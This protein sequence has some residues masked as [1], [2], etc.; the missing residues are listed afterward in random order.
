M[1]TELLEAKQ[2]HSHLGPYLVIGMKMGNF[3]RTTLGN[4]PFSYRI[5]TSVGLTPPTSCVIDGLQIT[6]PCTVGNSMIRVEELGDIA[7][8]A[9]QDD[10]RIELQLKSA[11]RKRIDNDTTRENEENIAQDLW[12]TEIEELFEIDISQP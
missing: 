4:K 9:Q 10:R 5:H 12:E 1:N 6:T 8:W 11:V 2:F 3:I 7:A